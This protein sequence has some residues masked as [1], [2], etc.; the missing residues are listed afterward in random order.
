LPINS[1]DKALLPTKVVCAKI[2]GY[3]FFKKRILRSDIAYVID[4]VITAIT[5]VNI[6]IPDH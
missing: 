3:F 1:L 6:G 4:P 5:F 2:R